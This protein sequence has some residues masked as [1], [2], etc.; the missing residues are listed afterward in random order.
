VGIATLSM[1]S[2]ID[3]VRADENLIQVESDEK[4]VVITRDELAAIIGDR[5]PTSDHRGFNLPGLLFL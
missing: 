1:Y 2:H 5:Y 3:S 4:A